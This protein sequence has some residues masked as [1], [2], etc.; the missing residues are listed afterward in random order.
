MMKRY[1]C[2]L[3]LLFT[4]CAT[5]AQVKKDQAYL[6]QINKYQKNYVDSHEVVKGDDK[7]YISFFAPDKKYK[8]TARFVKL[9]DTTGFIM[10]TS[11]AKTQQYFRYGTLHFTIDGKPLQLT[12][13][14]SKQL[15]AVKEFKDYLF[16]PYTDLTSGEESYGGGKYLELYINEI[17]SNTAIIDFNKAYN[18][19]C[20]YASG[21]NCPIPPRENNLGIAIKAGE[22]QFE[23]SH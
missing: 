1:F 2:F 12:V 23:K 20:A 11:G 7:K 8:V 16:I 14:Q 6:D 13:Y 22:K 5:N 15:M 18:P 3:M 19:Y 21:Y 17:V 10:K 4:C 9:N